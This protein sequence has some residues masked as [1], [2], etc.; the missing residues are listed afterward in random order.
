[1]PIRIRIPTPIRIRITILLTLSSVSIRS[2]TLDTLACAVAIIS[3][4]LFFTASE[5][6]LTSSVNLRAT[7]LS[8]STGHSENQSMDVQLARV[9]GK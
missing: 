1:M 9:R 7:S 2:D 6:R 4:T 5:P 8:A 3:V